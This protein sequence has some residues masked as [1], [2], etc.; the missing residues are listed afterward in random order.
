MRRPKASG[1]A[2]RYTSLGSMDKNMDIR[3]QAVPGGT[4]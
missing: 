4:A 2:P 1:G 3:I